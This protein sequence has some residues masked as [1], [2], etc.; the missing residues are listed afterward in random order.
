MTVA[1]PATDV[2]IAVLLMLCECLAWPGHQTF[3]KNQ[4]HVFTQLVTQQRADTVLLQSS[5]MASGLVGRL[6]NLFLQDRRLK[7]L[8]QLLIFKQMQ[9]DNATL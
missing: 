2:N 1:V 7:L 8:S 4:L 3:L 9:P 6:I 5:M